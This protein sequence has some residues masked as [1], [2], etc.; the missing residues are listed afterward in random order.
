MMLIY[1]SK[2]TLHIHVIQK[3]FILSSQFCRDMHTEMFTCELQVSR[4]KAR[5]T[6]TALKTLV[7]NGLL[8]R[9]VENVEILKYG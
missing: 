3:I 5:L 9:S 2:N 6:L 1:T 7:S 8:H 4:K